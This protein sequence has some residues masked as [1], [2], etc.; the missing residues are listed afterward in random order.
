MKNGET[1]DFSDMYESDANYAR[2]RWL[3]YYGSTY[4]PSGPKNSITHLSPVNY[5]LPHGRTYYA[6]WPIAIY[7][8]ENPDKLPGLGNEFWSRVWREQKP[9]EYWLDTIARLSDK[10]S[11]KDIFGYN[12]RRRSYNFAHKVEKDT[13]ERTEMKIVPDEPGWWQPPAE[14]APMQGGFDVIDLIPEG[15][16][17]VVTVDFKGLPDK[18]RGFDWRACLAVI[19]DKGG[20]RYTSL[21]NAGKQSV[22]LGSNENKVVLTVA[23]TPDKVY[24][25][26]FDDIKC[27]YRTD[28]SKARMQ[29]FIQVTGAKLVES[30]PKLDA[31]FHRHE[32]GGGKVAD[33]ALVEPSVYVGPN[34]I[35]SGSAKVAGSVRIEDFALVG[36]SAQISDNAIISGH[37]QVLGKSVV[38]DNAKVRDYAIIRNVT[39]S[40]DVRIL[41]HSSARDMTIKN[42]ATLKGRADCSSD[43]GSMISG[44]ACA[45]GD[46]CGSRALSNGFHYGHMPWQG[47]IWTDKCKAPSRIIAQY[48]F[49]TEYESIARDT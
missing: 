18:A 8:D 41:E 15:K 31:G 45:D 38:K 35:V 12:A 22:K 19:D 44:D 3:W 47:D 25:T 16:S 1:P 14:M 49:D 27:P 17:R 39:A 48:D 34:A 42:H 2:E 23:A 28:P 29:Y 7:L 21:W 32:N 37:A 20:E 13:C 4:D 33:S 30:S 11:L 40:D 36:D 43:K 26:D 5:C 9:N 46:W 10:V 24:P 6:C